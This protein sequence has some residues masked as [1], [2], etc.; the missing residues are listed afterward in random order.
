MRENSEHPMHAPPRDNFNR[1][2]PILAFL[3]LALPAGAESVPDSPPLKYQAPASLTA[4]IY[5][6]GGSNILFRFKRTAT[7]SGT[8]LNVLREYTRPDG[9]LVARETLTYHGDHL[10]AYTVDEL[11]SGTGGSATLLADPSDKTSGKIEFDFHAADGKSQKAT[12]SL[13]PNTLT[14]DM[15]APFLTDHWTD[16][17]NGHRVK[18]RYL[19]VSRKETIGFS[20]IR[21]SETDWHG[22]P[23]VMIRMEPSSWMIRQIVEPLYFTVEKEGQHRVLQYSGR[24]T[25]KVKSK[26]G[27][28]DLDALTVFDWE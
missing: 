20:F 26:N 4:T 2:I 7:R 23:V 14:S 8:N 11:Q 21:Q 17:V 28:K 25:P 27:W 22:K 10:A 18:A 3:C 1:I 24:T 12:Q 19:V 6:Q 13:P 9:Q 5:D 16:L 15:V